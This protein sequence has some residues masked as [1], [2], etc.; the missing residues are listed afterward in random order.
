MGKK[1]LIIISLFALF[2]FVDV[3]AL[4][5]SYN[6]DSNGISLEMNKGNGDNY[7]SVNSSNGFSFQ[8]F[9]SSSIS[10]KTKCPTNLYY[11]CNSSLKLCYVADNTSRTSFPTL[12]TDINGNTSLKTNYNGGGGGTNVDISGNMGCT[13]ILGDV[14]DKNSFLGFV[15]AYIFKPIRYIVPIVLIVLTSL[16]FAKAV[17]V[18]DEK[19]GI[20]KAKDNFVKRAIAALIIFL[21]PMFVSLLLNVI[22]DASI[23]EC[24]NSSDVGNL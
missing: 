15:S 24:L 22:N 21:A 10:T 14:N 13:G 7:W 19:D 23:S 11:K 3:K 12:A 18:G 16:D 8:I 2:M 4:S 1:V 20:N 6:R 9:S 5:C 17:F